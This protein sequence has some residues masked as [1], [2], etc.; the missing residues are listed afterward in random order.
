MMM[1]LQKHEPQKDVDATREHTLRQPGVPGTD[2]SNR[3][4]CH[5]I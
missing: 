3:T 5:G 1:N 4:N 2:V